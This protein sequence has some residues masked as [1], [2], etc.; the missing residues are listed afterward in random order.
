MFWGYFCLLECRRRGQE[1]KPQGLR[2]SA[3]GH[4]L[5]GC[6]ALASLDP[7][8]MCPSRHWAHRDPCETAGVRSRVGGVG[9][10][11]AGLGELVHGERRLARESSG[12]RRAIGAFTESLE[13]GWHQNQGD[14][15]DQE[16]PAEIFA[17]CPASLRTTSS[18]PPKKAPVARRGHARA[19]GRDS[20]FCLTHGTR[21]AARLMCK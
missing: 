18:L 19:L 10:A 14:S 8:S 12:Q 4:E 6:P 3:D 5:A 7:V 2:R 21:A 9:V 20:S 15:K 11:V 16:V 13:L 17:S 1:A